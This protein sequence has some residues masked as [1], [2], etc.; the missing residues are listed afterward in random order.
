MEDICQSDALKDIECETKFLNAQLT[1]DH[2]SQ[3]ADQLVQQVINAVI[4]FCAVVITVYGRDEY[5]ES[6]CS[7]Q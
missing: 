3:I 7:V 4:S 6:S 5:K 1:S 2:N